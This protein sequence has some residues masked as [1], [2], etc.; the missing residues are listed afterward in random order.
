METTNSSTFSFTETNFTIDDNYTFA[1]Q[2]WQCPICRRVYSPDTMMCPFCGNDTITTTITHDREYI[3][4]SEP[5][6]K[7]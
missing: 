4:R 7:K 1:R 3:W 5:Y 2:G 6:E